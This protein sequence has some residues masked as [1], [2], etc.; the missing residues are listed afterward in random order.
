MGFNDFDFFILLFMTGFVLFTFS[1]Y[2][3]L[4]GGLGGK[5]YLFLFYFLLLIKSILILFCIIGACIIGAYIMG[6]ST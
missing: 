6:A 1:I 4:N 3:L 2:Y 5:D